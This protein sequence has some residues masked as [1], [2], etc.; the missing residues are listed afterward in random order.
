[1]DPNDPRVG[2]LPPM[3][4]MGFRDS[5]LGVTTAGIVVILFLIVGT[6]V[7]G[8]LQDEQATAEPPK[9]EYSQEQFRSLLVGKT[10]DE[11]LQIIGSPDSTADGAEGRR[12]WTYALYDESI[13]HSFKVTDESSRGVLQFAQVWIGQNGRV[14]KVQY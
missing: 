2:E 8:R 1:M 5:L 13:K 3:Q 14:D 7:A 9:T 11:A 12:V 6:L 10:K 4:K